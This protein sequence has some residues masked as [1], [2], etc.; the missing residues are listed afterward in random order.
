[1]V[2]TPEASPIPVST[3]H[4]WRSLERESFFRAIERHKRA[5]WRVA[6]LCTLANGALAFV[7]ATLMSPLFYAGLALALDLINLAVPAPD[8]VDRIGSIL[9]PAFDH[10]ESV[11]LGHWFL[12][13]LIAAL[14]GLLWMS[15]LLAR[16][17]K[18]L[19]ASAGFAAGEL[20]AR[21]PSTAVLAEQRFANVV[22]EM[23]IAAGLPPPRVLIADRAALNA[24]VMGRDEQHATVVVSTSLLTSLDREQMQGVAAHLVASI[25]DGDMTIGSRAALTLS[26]F[27]TIAR[28][29]SLLSGN[30]GW[31]RIRRMG[32]T[33]LRPTG[34]G[35]QQLAASLADPFKPDAEAKGARQAR[36]GGPTSNKLDR[37][38]LA[39]AP[40]LGP[41]VITGF[42]GG[43]VSTF[44]L[45]PLLALTWR[46][47]KYMADAVAVRLT[48]DPDAL[49]EALVR[50]G[51]GPGFAPW[52]AHLCVA[53][54]SVAGT[55]LANSI[56]PMIPGKSRRL[57]ALQKMGAHTVPAPP[58]FPRHLL[59]LG[60]PLLTLV[61][62]LVAVAI[63]LTAW[64]SIPL[65]ML[66]TGLPFSAIHLLLRWLAK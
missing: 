12:W 24:L 32:L 58:M 40:L 34:P 3:P 42:L 19:R 26:L 22:E 13:A 55:W 57:K 8:L 62:A 60:A 46:Q 50:M 54:S 47:R 2:T 18:V 51:G 38:A 48:R 43:M 53:E 63:L 64:L 29:S 61:G 23:A 1:M 9:G 21:T 27:G 4:P 56:L 30:D 33:L 35:T 15:I 14:P 66:M 25:A 44:V 37:R 31:G 52:A 11:P 17:S 59:W 28:F 16:I 45:G 5:A 20:P 6:A 7:V 10:P 39:L 41:V 65:S 36:G 49:A